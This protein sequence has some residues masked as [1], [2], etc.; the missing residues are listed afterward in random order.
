MH[1]DYRNYKCIQRENCHC[2][3]LLTVYELALAAVQQRE[4]LYHDLHYCI[5]CGTCI[6]HQMLCLLWFLVR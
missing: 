6:T 2:V 4:T 5:H 3:F 1:S